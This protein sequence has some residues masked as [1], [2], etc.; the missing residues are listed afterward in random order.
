MGQKN[1]RTEYADIIDLPHHRSAARRHMSLYDRAAQFAPFAALT[2]FDDMVTEEARLTDS[3]IEL[4]EGEIAALNA[5]IVEI[6]DT[7]ENGSHP[8]VSVT[9]FRPDAHKSGGSYETLT[10][11]VKKVDPFEKMLILYGSEDIEDKRKPTIDIPFKT[12]V[13]ME[14][15]EP[16]TPLIVSKSFFIIMS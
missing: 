11:V 10:G 1:A 13:K 7:I 14:L 8:S 12:V 3:E 15:R 16:D 2:G 6:A 5:V 4:S 9:R